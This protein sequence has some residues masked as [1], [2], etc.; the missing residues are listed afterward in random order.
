MT[1]S[2][3]TGIAPG[4]IV[5]IFGANLG[6]TVGQVVYN[7]VPWTT[8]L[9]GITVTMDGTPVP[10]YRV[11]NLSGQEQLS[12]LAPFSIA[13]KTSTNIVVTNAAGT[14]SSVSVPVLPALPGIFILDSANNGA[15]HA[16]GTIVTAPSPAT[17]G[18]TVV[19]YLTGMGTV[20]NAP[21]AG[22]PAS[23]TTLSPTTFTPI[24]TMGGMP[25]QVSFSGLTPGF[26][27]LYQ[28][29][30]VVP[31]GAAGASLDMT[32]QVNNVT[33]NTAKIALQ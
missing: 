6:A 15:V 12:L 10:I 17:H 27:G 14:S 19:L 28:I 20:S 16:N 25:A 13:G 18:E 3:P 24:V 30:A 21:Q 23:L 33:R 1:S 4:A 2:K 29:N 7:V 32:V 11:L 31:G 8:S 22:Q 5:T 9:S 26:I